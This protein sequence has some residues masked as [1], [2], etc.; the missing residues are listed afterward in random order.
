MLKEHDFCKLC[1]NKDQLAVL[2]T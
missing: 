1:Q 2:E